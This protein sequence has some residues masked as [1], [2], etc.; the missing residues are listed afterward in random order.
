MSR[1]ITAGQATS[2]EIATIYHQP[3]DIAQVVHRTRCALTC[4][5]GVLWKHDGKQISGHFRCATSRQVRTVPALNEQQNIFPEYFASAFHTLPLPP[6]FKDHIF[7][8]KDIFLYW[9]VLRL[10]PC[11]AFLWEYREDPFVH[12]QHVPLKKS[13]G[14]REGESCR[15]RVAAREALSYPGWEP[16]SAHLLFLVHHRDRRQAFG[17]RILLLLA[18]AQPVSFRQSARFFIASY[19]RM[20]A[21]SKSADMSLG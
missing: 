5:G 20:V 8:M 9:Y 7:G 18:Q 11:K 14:Q 12:H 6:H 10:H 2:D 17:T 4:P 21:G 1:I 13:L 15:Y 16:L 19:K 3:Y